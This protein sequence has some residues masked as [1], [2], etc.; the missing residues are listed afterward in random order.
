LP[1]IID[2]MGIVLA[3]TWWAPLA[4]IGG[5]LVGATVGYLLL[6]SVGPARSETRESDSRLNWHRTDKTNYPSWNPV[7]FL[8]LAGAVALVVGLAIGL[9]VG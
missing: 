2:G 7:A 1:A 6:V 9:S 5:A 4:I 8:V 3:V